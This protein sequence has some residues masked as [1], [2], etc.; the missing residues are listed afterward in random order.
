MGQM[1][2]G[3]QIP[4]GVSTSAPQ[5]MPGMQNEEGLMVFQT[6]NGPRTIREMAQELHDS[7]IQIPPGEDPAKIYAIQSQA[8]VFMEQPD[9]PD[10]MSP[11]NIM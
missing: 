1:S 5:I 8:P 10:D 3:L 7:G 11:R 2:G 4:E 9:M 6:G